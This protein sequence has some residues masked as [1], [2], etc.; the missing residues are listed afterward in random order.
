MDMRCGE[1]TPLSRRSAITLGASAS[2][3]L[4]M[5]DPFKATAATLDQAEAAHSGLIPKD[6]FA[7][8]RARWVDHLT[9]NS[10]AGNTSPAVRRR[11]GA[12]GDTAARRLADAEQGNTPAGSI[13]ANLP[14]DGP[15][16]ANLTTTYRRIADVAL[17][18]ATAG[19]PQYHRP[20][21]R[22]RLVAWYRAMSE[23]WYHEGAEPV[24][25][26]WFWEIG[27]PRVLGDITILLW[28]K[29]S[30]AD[31]RR[32]DR[33][34]RHFTPDPNRIERSD[35]PATGPNRADKAL[36]CLLRGIAAGSPQD[37]ALARD[38]LADTSGG[39]AHSL[40]A[41]TTSG[42]GFYQDGSFIHHLRLPYAG[43]Y[44]KAALAAVAPSIMLL[45]DTRWALDTGTMKPLLD[46]VERTFRPFIW[47]GR[48]LAT[49]RGRAVSRQH[50]TAQ[51]DGWDTI[52]A[53]MLL[54]GFVGGE[55]RGTYRSVAKGWLERSSGDYASGATTITD[56]RRAEDLLGDPSVNPAPEQIGHVRTAAQ[57]R[58]VHRGDG[59]AFTVATS[60]ARIGRYGWGNGENRFGWYQGDGASYLYLADDPEQFSDDYWPTV[61]PYR[62]PGT[63][64]SVREREPG[65]NS[66]TPVPPAE[67]LW[68]GGV[69]LAGRWGTAGMQLTG[70]LGDVTGKK[71]WFALGDSIVA[72]GSGIVVTGPGAETT[73]ENRSFPA[74]GAP[75]FVVEGEPV[76]DGSWRM[77]NAPRWAHIEGV[78]G[79]V[80]L[81][82]Y[83]ARA[84]LR[85]RT[86]SW[87][88]INIGGDTAGSTDPRTRAY[89]TLSLIHP[90]GTRGDRYSYVILPG[91]SASATRDH[92]TGG[93]TTVVRDDPRAHVVRAERGGR[94]F[95]FA[96]LWEAVDD[97]PVRADGPCAIA[98]S[99]NGSTARIAVC[100][101]TWSRDRLS[102]RIETPRQYARLTWRSDRLSVGTGSPVTVD[103]DASAA[104]GASFEARLDR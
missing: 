1:Q 57:E 51:R 23:R 20:A 85:N 38:A 53:I 43:T 66:G 7:A 61:D 29:L 12:L 99:G 15:D 27:I 65:P 32:T 31:R 73:V 11:I 104:G 3:A 36:S 4:V 101:P 14:I 69:S 48:M 83:L 81:G 54:S 5:Y 37:M 68:G 19:T 93:T 84:Q 88:D 71:S 52:E 82:T 103:A 26:W 50:E 59:W 89:A 2:L 87:R 6:D 39:G 49:V 9:G 16:A 8:L 42:D 25:N 67:N 86:G 98:A 28:D 95:L 21:V 47:N 30:V 96:H 34:L 75:R 10:G 74:G 45:A 64:A 70:A 77:L 35:R 80:F 92:A 46:S 79:Y 44:G 40:F 41:Y 90:S 91:A 18:W 63:T 60:S 58:M 22:E 100:D 24:G 72:V 97:G 62:L 102:I 78:A 56:L 55:H 33:A 76:D 13:W 17:A 94:W